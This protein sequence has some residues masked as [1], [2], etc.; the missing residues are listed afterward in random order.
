[1]LLGTWQQIIHLDCDV[2]PRSRTI[3]VKLTDDDELLFFTAST[4]RKVEDLN[5]N[6][7]TERFT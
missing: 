6:S 1:M 3:V 7:R 2:K 4:S 5:A